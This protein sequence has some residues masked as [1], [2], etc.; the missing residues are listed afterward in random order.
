M[1][2]YKNRNGVEFKCIKTKEIHK[3][4]LDC[5]ASYDTGN[6]CSIDYDC[7]KDQAFK[8][9]DE[10][11]MIDTAIGKHIKQGDTIY[12]SKLGSCYDCALFNGACTLKNYMCKGHVCWIKVDKEGL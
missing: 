10:S 11:K 12:V 6:Y 9:V 8:I 2:I 4:M 5:D 7:Y 3:C 1:K